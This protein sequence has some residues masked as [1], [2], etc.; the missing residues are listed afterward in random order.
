MSTVTYPSSIEPNSVSFTLVDPAIYVRSFL[1]GFMQKRSFSGPR[2]GVTL[3][4][5]NL[6]NAQEAELVAAFSQLAD[7]GDVIEIPVHGN[8]Q[9]G[10]FG[11]TP[12]VDG[13][14]QIGRSLAV[15]GAST[16]VTDWIKGGDYFQVGTELK[17][18]TADSNSDGSG[19]LTLNFLPRIRTSPADNAAITTTDP[20]GLFYLSEDGLSWSKRPGRFY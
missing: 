8:T 7:S 16:G 12:L 20:K 1:S 19:D 6:T 15:D 10:N 14:S 18:A 5:V 17:R 11:G 3:N 13:A 9:Q 4:Y 2:W